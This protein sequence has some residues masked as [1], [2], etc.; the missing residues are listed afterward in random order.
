MVYNKI[1]I[2]QAS[3]DLQ[4]ALFLYDQYKNE[5]IKICV[6]NVKSIHDYL[7]QLSLVNV[8]LVF[9]PYIEFKIKNPLTYI[10]ARKKMQ[11]IWHRDFK[12]DTV[13]NV[14]FFSRFYDWFTA[15]LIVN[16][17]KQGGSR[18]FYYDHYDDKSVKNDVLIDNVSIEGV[19]LK[20]RALIHSYIAKAKMEAH[21]QIR[22][23]EFAFKKYDI[24]KIIPSNDIIVNEDYLYQ[25]NVKTQKGILFFLSPG[26]IEMLDD[27][28]KII[29]K[30]IINSLKK[31][32]CFLMLKGHPRLGNPTEFVPFFDQIIPETIPSEFIDY[33]GIL[34][35]V[36][37][38]STA[39]NF[40]TSKP[41]V[42]VISLINVLP[43]KEENKK[44]FYLNYLKELSRN[45]ISFVNSVDL[46]D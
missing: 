33:N 42:E 27:R 11:K 6:I 17:L 18:I 30:K 21:H 45:K 28:S 46:T 14:Y 25:L 26:E 35:T 23:L 7:L 31:E 13:D 41:K 20:L 37:I 5:N 39:L 2:I 9:Y 43:F 29:L 4:H 12:T 15:S 16:F 10:A 1:I 36:G 40:A 22:N 24:K 8:T 19:K 34:K 38:I 3:A 44:Q 32:G